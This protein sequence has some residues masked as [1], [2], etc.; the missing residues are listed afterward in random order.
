MVNEMTKRLKTSDNI[1]P[2][3]NHVFIAG[4]TGTGKSFL[5]ENYLAHYQNVIKLDT[6]NVVDERRRENKN[7]WAGL[8]ENRD[9]S[10][11]RTLDELAYIET[12]KIIYAPDFSEQTPENYDILFDWIFRRENNILWIDEFTDIGTASYCPTNLRRLYVQGRSKNVGVWA[13]TQR[14]SGIPVISLA[15]S[16]HFFIFDLN[17]D[18]DRKKVAQITG[19]PEFLEMPGGFNFWYYRVGSKKAVKAVLK[20]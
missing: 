7:L 16:R 1:I 19:Q 17:M 5:C 13:C 9:F 6:K 11:V 8:T 20:I 18:V 12:P 3:D 10:V 14:P 15:N 4:M 2:T